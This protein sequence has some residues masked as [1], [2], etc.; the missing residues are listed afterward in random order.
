MFTHDLFKHRLFSYPMSI[1]TEA[2][3]TIVAAILA[4]IPVGISV[5]KCYKQRAKSRQGGN[6]PMGY[7]L[8][9]WNPCV[10]SH[11]HPLVLLSEP[12]TGHDTAPVP[13]DLLTFQLTRSTTVSEHQ[14]IR[15]ALA[16]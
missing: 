8:P 3:V 7:L 15:R 11:V 14:I 9:I 16:A 13:S 4:S 1:S 12:S 6:K 2:T 5:F 10:V